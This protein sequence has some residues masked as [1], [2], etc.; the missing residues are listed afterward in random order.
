MTIDT[1][2]R[3]IANATPRVKKALIRKYPHLW[4]QHQWGHPTTKAQRDAAQSGWAVGDPA[5]MLAYAAMV[6]RAMTANGEVDYSTSPQK[7]WI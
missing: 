2:K 4:H 1:F 7:S 3:R 6:M 5:A